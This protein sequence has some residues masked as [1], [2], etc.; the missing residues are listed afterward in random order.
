MRML[1]HAIAVWA[2]QPRPCDAPKSR[3]S[4]PT[5]QAFSRDMMNIILYS[6]ELG[7]KHTGKQ[8]GNR[9]GRIK[10]ESPSRR[11]DGQRCSSCLVRQW[12]S[13]H[14]GGPTSRTSSRLVNA[15]RNSPL[16]KP[17]LPSL[18][19]SVLLIHSLFL[20]A[21]SHSIYL[22]PAWCC[23]HSP[24]S[25]PR[26]TSRPKDLTPPPTSGCD[27]IT[28]KTARQRSDN[29]KI[30]TSLFVTALNLRADTVQ[31][32]PMNPPPQQYQGPPPG[33]DYYNAPPGQPPPPQGYGPAYPPQAYYGP[34][35]QN[36]M[37][38]GPPQPQGQGQGGYYD[39]RT[40][41]RGYNRGR[42]ATQ[43]GICA[44]LLAGA[45]LSGSLLLL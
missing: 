39:D 16:S 14:H 25:I 22:H 23:P 20:C 35:P 40:Y 27:P 31:D 18:S 29:A 3:R 4:Q 13:L 28:K 26:R 36:G 19:L 44:G 1:K 45:V 33:P 10:P 38:Y 42:S 24:I 41:D 7:D 9:Q 21:Q 32:R 8:Q 34:P 11:W 2:A 17:H 30:R 43:D 37:Y 12:R 15:V 6:Q 5:I